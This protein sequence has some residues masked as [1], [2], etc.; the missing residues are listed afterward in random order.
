MWLNMSKRLVSIVIPVYNEEKILETAVLGLINDLEPYRKDFDFEIILAENG[1]S[2]KTI[3][4]GKELSVSYPFVSIFHYPDPDYLF[5]Y[6]T[7]IYRQH[8]QIRIEGVIMLL[9]RKEVQEFDDK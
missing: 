1:S 5:L 4:K 7:T 8:C 3:E 2:D 9:M 6:T